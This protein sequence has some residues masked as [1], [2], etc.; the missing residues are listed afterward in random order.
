MTSTPNT[1]PITAPV[2][3][4][5]EVFEHNEVALICEGDR[6]VGLITRIDL[7]NYLRQHP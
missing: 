2:T 5:L 4:L 7:I 3:A 6:F 1:L